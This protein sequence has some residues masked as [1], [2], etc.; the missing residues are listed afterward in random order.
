V[1]ARIFGVVDAFDALTSNRPY[2]T[3]MSMEEAVEYLQS[4]AGISFDPAI[5][6]EFGDMAADGMLATLI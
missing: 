4:Q 2:R 1:M 6:K 5:V 3:P